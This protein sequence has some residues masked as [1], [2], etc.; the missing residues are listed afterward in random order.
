MSTE[1]IRR[2]QELRR[3]GAAGT[4]KD[5]RLGRLRTRLASKLRAIKE[6]S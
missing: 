6:N 3:S 2:T 5:K 4:H 1:K